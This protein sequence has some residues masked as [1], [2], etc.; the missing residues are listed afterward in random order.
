MKYKCKKCGAEIIID[1]ETAHCY[2]C[3]SDFDKD[4]LIEKF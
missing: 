3:N 2:G 4:L 1:R